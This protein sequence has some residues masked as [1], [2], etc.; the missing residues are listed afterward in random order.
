MV[1][2]WKALRDVEGG[3]WEEGRKSGGKE[4]LKYVWQ[5]IDD[6]DC[7]QSLS[8]MFGKSSTRFIQGENL[9]G[10]LKVGVKS[11]RSFMYKSKVN[12]ELVGE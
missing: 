5:I 8:V 7:E 12:V 4:I 1:R 9:I 3:S 11:A 6:T 2:S 10:K